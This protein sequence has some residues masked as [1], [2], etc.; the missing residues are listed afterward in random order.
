MKQIILIAA[1]GENWSLGYQGSIPWHLPND[2]KRF[3]ALTTGHSIIMGRKTFET[4][5]KPLPNRKHLII[6]RNL[7]FTPHFEA[8]VFNDLAGALTATQQE[9]TVFII[10]GG[11]IY[12]LALP[13]ATK[14]ELTK[15]HGTFKADAFFPEIDEDLWQLEQAQ[16]QPKDAKHHYAFTYET[17]TRK[18][19]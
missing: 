1:V 11:E 9:E 5:P 8:Q 18:P 2:F 6:T 12:K 10:G 3:K 14:I 17:Y 15:V 4:F 16:A 13:F 7:N 19:G